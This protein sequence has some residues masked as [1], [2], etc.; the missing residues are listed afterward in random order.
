MAFRL[1]KRGEVAPVPEHAPYLPF[2]RLIAGSPAP[3]PAPVDPLR[4]VAVLQ[5]TGGTTGLP[6]AAMLSHANIVINV[7]QV[8]ASGL[9]LREGQERIMGVLPLFHVFAMT[10]V[11]NLGVALGAELL[12]L[13]RP[14]MKP[15]MRL[16]RRRRPTLLMGVPTLFNAISNAAEAQGADLSFIKFGVSGGAPIAAE[17]AERFT[18]ITGCPILE[19]Y[20]LSE[21]APV[22]TLNPPDGVRRGS[23]G[24]ALP[25][26]LIEIRD[27]EQPRRQMPAGE[28]GEICVGGPQVM[29][30]YHNQPE[31][32]ANAFVDG[33]LRTGD[34]G[35]MDADGYLFIVDRIKDLILCGGYNV[36]PRVIEEA[37]YQH[38]AVREAVAIGVP[39]A[40]RGQAPKLF[41]TL[42]PGA[43]ATG[44]QIRQM[45]RQHLNKIELPVV[46]EIRDTLPKTLIG[47]LSKKSWW[48]RKRRSTP[49]AVALS[50]TS[51]LHCLREG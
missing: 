24:Q 12:L 51:C 25:G 6:K 43:N 31:E 22:L 28:K 20:G 9:P 39:D 47:K 27:P 7:R 14:E 11:M 41:V 42:C 32:T 1:F 33:L 4:D 18:R 16:M 46:V 15:M 23:V 10:G 21:T 37:A 5:F 38:P 3:A 45:L 48:R 50:Y 29:R 40:H 35:T 26:T 8:L 36:Y 17:V 2:E 19:G 34:I 44:E 30:G 13:P 49:E